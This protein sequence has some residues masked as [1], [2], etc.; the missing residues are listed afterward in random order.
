MTCNDQTP[1]TPEQLDF[2]LCDIATTAKAAERI[3]ILMNHTNDGRDL[4]AFTVAL[5]NLSQR[6]G[7]A[8]DMAMERSARS[9]GPCYGDATQWM[10]P[11]LF[12]NAA[13]KPTAARP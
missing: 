6:M 10:M 13:D 2:V 3:S 9:I 7:W 8:A 11:P 5:V 4:E 1:L 12:H